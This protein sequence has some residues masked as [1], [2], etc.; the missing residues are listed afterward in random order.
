MNVRLSQQPRTRKVP[1]NLVKSVLKRVFE[2]D[3]KDG[4]VSVLF[5]D[6]EGI[7]K[8]NREY[9]DIDRPTDV[10]SFALNEG[11][12]TDPQPEMWGDIVISVE[13][14]ARQA[15]ESGELFESEIARLLI[16][17]ALHLLGYEHEQSMEE[18]ERMER[19]ELK[20]LSGIT[21]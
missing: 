4:E 17:G 16:H 20:I 9:R 8:L 5:L 13:S 21:L 3:H 19:M 15:E 11:E 2:I 7:R 10:L 1:L 12:L 14:A 18:A 6:D